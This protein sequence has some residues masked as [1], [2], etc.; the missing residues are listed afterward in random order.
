[1][2]GFVGY[3]L[4]EHNEPQKEEM[5]QLTKAM[6]VIIHRGPEDVGFYTDEYARLGS[7]W[8]RTMDLKDSQQP[9]SYADRYLIVFD[10]KIYNYIE[11]RKQL[12]NKG[13]TFQTTSDVEVLIVLYIDKQASALDDLRGMFSFLIWDKQEKE[14]FGARDPFGIKPF[15]MVENE[16]ALYC[17]SEMKSLQ[18]LIEE[19]TEGKIKLEALQHYFSF[20]YVPE[21]QTT[22]PS[23]F[24]LEPGHFF[25]KKP[26]ESIEIS[27]Y[28]QS[29]FVPKYRSFKEQTARIQEALRESVSLHMRSG[30][31]IGAF[32]SG[33]VDSSAIVALAKEINPSI[34]TFTVGFKREGY[35]EIEVAKE[36]AE[37]LGVENIHHVITSEEFIKELPNVIRYM[38]DPVA[39]PAAVPLY[40]VAREARKNVNVVLSGEG[41]DE[42]FGGYNIYREPG[43]LKIFEKIPQSLQTVLQSLAKQLP[44]GVR[45]KSL[46]ERGTTSIENR[47]IGNAKLFS[48][49]EKALLVKK[50]QSDYHF[51]KITQPLY[52]Q[53]QHYPDV[54]KMQYIDL[55][56]WARGDILV[57]AD[58]M[59]M[60]HSLELRVPFLDQKVFRVASELHPK[61]TITNRTTKYA[62]REAMR[63]IVPDSVLYNKKLGFPVPIRHWLR[64]ELWDWAKVMIQSSPTDDFI[65]KPYVLHLLK[66]HQRGKVDYSRKVWAVLVFMI[67]Y[68]TVFVNNR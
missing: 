7:R 35:C 8:L 63:G 28:W 43:A 65:H 1:M 40:I 20:Q 56:T 15:Y 17:A 45:G 25:R 55:H 62:L 32:L 21:P 42:L 52:D 33:G 50:Y 26:G 53:I 39:D 27:T 38:D 3:I 6:N 47:F 66:V 11:L 19:N 29:T 30:V 23:I 37:Q 22:Q 16:N 46:L 34:Q 5:D 12:E 14:L 31:P 9:F 36:T 54:H 10:G 41:A 13:Y 68:E 51:K 4:N 49:A 24:K 57:K 18:P 44:E 64:N 48:E 2:S 60:A 61:Q 59:T 58:R 67:W